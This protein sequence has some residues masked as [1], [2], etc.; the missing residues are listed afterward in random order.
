MFIRENSGSAGGGGMD[1]CRRMGFL[2]EKIGW[3]SCGRGG[4]GTRLALLRRI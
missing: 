3:N 2:N 1:R 4:M